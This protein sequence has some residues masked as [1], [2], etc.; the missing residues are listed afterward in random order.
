VNS[1]AEVTES[2]IFENVVI[3]RHA[4]LRRCIIDKDVDIPPGMEIGFDLEKDRQRFYVSEKGIVVV[5][6]R[7]KL[8]P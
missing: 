4:R 7:A 6:K 5:P 1:F 8:T 2:V 3:G